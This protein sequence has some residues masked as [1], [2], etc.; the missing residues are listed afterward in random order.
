MN[1]NHME[2]SA[3]AIDNHAW[4]ID[5]RGWKNGSHEKHKIIIDETTFFWQNFKL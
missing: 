3:S 2:L 5:A 4:N 1:L